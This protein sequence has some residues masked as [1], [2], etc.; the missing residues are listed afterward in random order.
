M[1]NFF[2]KN[3]ATDNY[4]VE[5]LCLGTH[6]FWG[7]VPIL[8]AVCTVFVVAAQRVSLLGTLGFS[9]YVVAISVCGWYPLFLRL[10]CNF[11]QSLGTHV[12]SCFLWLGNPDFFGLVLSFCGCYW[13]FLCLAHSFC[14][15]YSVCCWVLIFCDWVLMVSVIKTNGF[16][17]LVPMDCVDD[18]Q[19]LSLLLGTPSFFGWVL[20]FCNWYPWLLWLVLTISKVD[21]SG[22]YFCTQVGT[23]GFCDL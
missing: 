19:L 12:C 18:T 9:V 8:S 22:F 4:D 16:Q 21:T 3:S 5:F 17:V 20:S 2:E 15:R 13:C 14:G 23:H 6:T 11:F 1:F 10:S 7:W